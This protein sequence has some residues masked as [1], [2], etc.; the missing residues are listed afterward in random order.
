MLMGATDA[1]FIRDKG[2]EA[3]GFGLFDPQ[4]PLSH[5]VEL[6]HGTNERVSIKTVELTLNAHYDLAK[7][8]L[9]S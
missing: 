8:V 7:E 3:Y 5:L 4:T 1:R 2:A 9:G 6:A